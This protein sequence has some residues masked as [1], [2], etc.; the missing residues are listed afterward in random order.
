[1]TSTAQE[2]APAHTPSPGEILATELEA[3]GWSQRSFAQILDKPPQAVNEILRA[4]KQI[5]PETALR[6]AAAL[7]TSPELWLN[8]EAEYRL[9]LARQE[10]APVVLHAI[11]LRSAETA[12]AVA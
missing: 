2:L 9:A 7:G 5:T 4:K 8:L 12:S 6:I 1:M 3:R 10:I 11:E